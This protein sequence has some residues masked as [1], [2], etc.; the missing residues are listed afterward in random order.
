MTFL[1]NNIPFS[2]DN[3]SL[4]L[5]D[6]DY[7]IEHFNDLSP[8]DQQTTLTFL[9]YM[10]EL[11]N[12]A[13]DHN[14]I[15][16]NTDAEYIFVDYTD[17]VVNT[18]TNHILATWENNYQEQLTTIKKLN[19]LFKTNDYKTLFYNNLKQ[20]PI[21]YLIKE[22][23]EFKLKQGETYLKH[24]E[25]NQQEKTPTMTQTYSIAI[26]DG[27]SM[28]I[29]IKINLT[30]KEALKEAL[31]HLEDQDITQICNLYAISTKDHKVALTRIQDIIEKHLK[32]DNE[33]Y[34]DNTDNDNTIISINTSPKN[35]PLNNIR[36]E[37]VGYNFFAFAKQ[38]KLP[39]N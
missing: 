23:D 34:Y 25:T 37:V 38:E 28:P 30:F 32:E 31:S 7:L 22:D 35:E 24:L 10:E 1:N 29:D 6:D 4:A 16:S 15:T 27:G 21:E 9:H 12:S 2:I 13:N 18:L 3:Y 5:C 33:F 14:P 8:E 11:K 36:I 20:T 39:L 26:T 17:N 19:Q